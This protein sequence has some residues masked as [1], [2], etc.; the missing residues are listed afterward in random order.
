MKI[1]FANDTTQYHG[2]SWAVCSVIRDAAARAGHDIV[3]EVQT[4]IVE[5]DIIADCDA[6]LVNGEGTIHG[7]G[8]RARHLMA[9]LAYGQAQGKSTAL[10]NASWS[11]MTDEFD[12][13]LHKLDGL[14]VRE[15]RSLNVL[16]DQH[17]VA[18][19]IAVDLSFSSP[20]RSQVISRDVDVLMTDFYS[21]EFACA[22]RP[23]GLQFLRLPFHDMRNATWQE[24]LDAVGGCKLLLTGRYH[25][26]Y[27][28]I[29]ARTPFVAYPGNTD[30]IEG[31]LE[32]SGLSLPLA[33]KPK[34]IITLS[35]DIARYG[36]S[37]ERFFDWIASQPAWRF[38]F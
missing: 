21:R 26:L 20:L 2:G 18:A 29:V 3:T 16:R 28:A 30:K 5:E 32:W 6:V 11:G 33:S 14:C 38:P 22:V 13:V 10:C 27:A 25:G 23:T 9:V 17:G 31:L 1:Y 19:E 37:F 8:A 4:K 34:Q 36:D 15:M 7:N 12:A 24:T 35:R